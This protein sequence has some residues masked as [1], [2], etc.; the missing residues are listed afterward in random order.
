MSNLEYLEGGK[1]NCHNIDAYLRRNVDGTI[2]YECNY[3][4]K[5]CDLFTQPREPVP[6]AESL[7][8]FKGIMDGLEEQARVMVK[9]K[10]TAALLVENIYRINSLLALKLKELL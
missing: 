5:A 10:Q 9:E 2:Y 3:C 1:S 4:K 8:Y 7:M 6:N